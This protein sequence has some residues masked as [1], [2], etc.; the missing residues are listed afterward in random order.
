MYVFFNTC[1]APC[2]F[3]S[4]TA[5]TARCSLKYSLV[6][7]VGLF[8][9]HISRRW[10]QTKDT[11]MCK[12]RCTQCK[13]T[14]V[15]KYRRSSHVLLMLR[16]EMFVGHDRSKTQSFFC[17]KTS[18]FFRSKTAPHPKYDVIYA[19]QIKQNELQVLREPAL[20]VT[21]EA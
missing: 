3:L 8:S 19:E 9:H 7:F 10:M 2:T 13:C 15:T 17:V 1:A 20:F 18:I 6:D 11:R 4:T 16:A 5:N 12:S 21:Q 14:T